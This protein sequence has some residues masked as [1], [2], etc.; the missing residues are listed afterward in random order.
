M[1]V[2]VKPNHAPDL[3]FEA[4]TPASNTVLR[5]G[6]WVNNEVMTVETQAGTSP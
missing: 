2:F 5:P 4:F 1:N 3:P 6:P